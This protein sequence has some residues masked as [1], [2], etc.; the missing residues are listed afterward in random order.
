[1]PSCLAQKHL[2]TWTDELFPFDY[3][4]WMI[5]FI[6][7]SWNHLFACQSWVIFMCTMLMPFGSFSGIVF[8]S[9]SILSP[10]ESRSFA[11]MWSTT[12]RLERYSSATL[13]SIPIV[14]ESFD[15]YLQ[16]QVQRDWSVILIGFFIHWTHV[17]LFTIELWFLFACRR[18]R[19]SYAL[20]FINLQFSALITSIS[21]YSPKDPMFVLFFVSSSNCPSGYVARIWNSVLFLFKFE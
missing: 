3:R 4:F 1:M 7:I 2:S 19:C 17:V 11:S 21:T 13:V 18:V 20:R 5:F 16:Y 8:W 6:E 12:F 15:V 14:P 9:V 10:W